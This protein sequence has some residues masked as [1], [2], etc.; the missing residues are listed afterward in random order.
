M[1]PKTVKLSLLLCTLCQLHTAAFA[2]DSRDRPNIVFILIDDMGWKDLGCMGST[3]YQTPRIDALADEGVLFDQAYACAPVCSPSRGAILSG[4]FPGRTAFTNVF[5]NTTTPD[6]RLYS[7][8]KNPGTREQ[9]LEAR[10][11]RALPLSE[12]T[13][14]EQLVKAGY[15]TAMFGKWH[16]GYE[17]LHRPENRGFQIAEGY[18][19]APSSMG[20]WGKHAIGNISG[21]KELQPADYVPEV[22]T[23]YATEFISDNR[24]DSFLL[25]LSHYIVHGPIQGKPDKVAKYRG[26]PTA[27]Q[28]NP[29]N[30]AM[31]E[32][33]DDS[34]GAILDTL[35]ELGLAEN[36]LIVFTSDNG[37]VSARA[38]SS[39]PLMGGKSFPY[40]AGM[41]VP[42]IV[43][44]PSRISG[45]RVISERVTGADL[46]PTFLDSANLPLM[47]NQ[48]V[49]GESLLPLLVEKKNLPDRDIVVHFPHYTHATGPFASII[50]KNWKLIRYYNNT[51]GEYEL[52]NLSDDPFEQNNLVNESPDRFSEM[53]RRLTAWQ[54]SANTFAP[55]ENTAY[56][57]GDNTPKDRRFTR[58]L[59][60]KERNRAERKLKESK[61]SKTSA[62]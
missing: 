14:A 49:D 38:T 47:P 37:G 59:A 35:E 52:F 5:E 60:L 50:Y 44:W 16:T 55:L 45:G 23:R 1:S 4:K 12:T 25:F 36:T 18:R 24:D 40:E 34:V 29:E 39:Y 6:D 7:V 8:S 15:K 41:R 10:H 11:R 48:H 46:Y 22:L 58:S 62:R 17:A 21:L 43:R 53:K 61:V 54:A 9:H 26:L 30:A 13:F 2:Q 28:D 33:V 51:S 3:Y 32:S 27:E 19:P 20:H 42:M 57:P 31:V 56:T